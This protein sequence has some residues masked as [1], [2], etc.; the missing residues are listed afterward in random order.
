MI[1]ML[2]DEDQGIITAEKILIAASHG[3]ESRILKVL[4]E[5]VI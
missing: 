5:L 1:T 3:P 2:G 4:K